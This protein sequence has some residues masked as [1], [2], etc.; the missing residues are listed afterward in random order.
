V[1]VALV[2][3]TDTGVGKT[4]VTRALGYALTTAGRR[5]RAIKPLETGCDGSAP[6]DEDGA[7]LAIATG[8]SSP[9]RALRRFAA[10]L[11]PAMATTDRIDLESL[12]REIEAYSAGMEF[13]LV[14]GAGGLL[15]PLGWEWNA[16]DLARELGAAALVVASDRLGTINHTLL[17]LGALEL[18]GIDVRGVALTPPAQADYSTGEN[19]AAILRLSGL[20]RVITLPRERDPQAA[21]ASLIAAIKWLEQG[22]E[23]GPPETAPCPERSARGAYPPKPHP[24]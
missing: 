13:V 18:A 9:R 21:G 16:I 15:A 19:A 11:A 1:K 2:T 10:P 6:D 5:V 22:P 12:V 7:L 23:T 17:T 14:E 3:G 4:W 24:S 20:D 8:Q